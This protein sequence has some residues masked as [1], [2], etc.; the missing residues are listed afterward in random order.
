[1][2]GKNEATNEQC[3]NNAVCK[4]PTLGRSFVLG[5]LYNAIQEKNLPGLVM[6]SWA[7]IYFIFLL[8]NLNNLGLN[9]WNKKTVSHFS[10]VINH[11]SE[12]LKWHK[13]LQ[14]L[15]RYSLLHV[16]PQQNMI[17]IL[18]DWI[19]KGKIYSYFYIIITSFGKRAIFVKSF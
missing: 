11:P 16:N 13:N 15:D 4:L 14:V 5:G 19:D 1:M 8:V 3:S 7:L 9:L 12:E 6:T 2:C 10:S 17:K 18:D